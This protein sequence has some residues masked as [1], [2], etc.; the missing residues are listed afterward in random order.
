M[1]VYKNPPSPQHKTAAMIALCYGSTPEL[2]QRTFQMIDT[3]VREQD[4]MYFFA[5]SAANR[6]SRRE[7]WQ[8]MKATFPALQK[9]FTG[10]FSLSRLISVRALRARPG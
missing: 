1:S 4:V 9:R 7:L 10:N 2:R 5:G 6:A 3:D 8:H